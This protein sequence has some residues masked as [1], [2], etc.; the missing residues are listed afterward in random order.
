ML[1]IY[2]FFNHYLGKTVNCPDAKAIVYTMRESQYIECI[3]PAYHFAS[4]KLL[5]LLMD[6]TDLKKR[7]LYVF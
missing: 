4:K 1:R 6:D 3:E 7:L 5:D 2:H